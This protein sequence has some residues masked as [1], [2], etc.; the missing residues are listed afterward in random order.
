MKSDF[1][2]IGE[3]DLISSE[4]KTKISSKHRFAE[5]IAR[6]SPCVHDFIKTC[7]L[8]FHTMPTLRVAEKG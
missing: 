6:I 3:A 2:G 5:Q 8:H 7:K 4:A 1:D